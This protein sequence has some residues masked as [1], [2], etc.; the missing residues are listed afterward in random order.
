MKVVLARHGN[1]FG[2][3]DTPVWVGARE[4]YPLVEKGREQSTAIGTYLNR[5]S[6]VPDLSLIHI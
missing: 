2:P 3:G 4:D 5:H 6:I 1:T